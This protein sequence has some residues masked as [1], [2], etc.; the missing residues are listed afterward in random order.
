MCATLDMRSRACNCTSKTQQEDR[1][2]FPKGYGYSPMKQ[3]MKSGFQS[4]RRRVRSAGVRAGREEGGALYELAMV[5]PVLSMLLVGIIYG[6]ITFY[7]YV[8]LANAVA[9]GAR[10]LALN[11]SAFAGPP[12]ACQLEEAALKNAAGNLNPLQITIAPESFVGASKCSDLLQDDTATVSATYPCNL[13]IPFAGINL[14]P[15]QGTTSKTSNA[16]CPNSAYCLSATMTV[17]IQ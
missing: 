3:S 5:A 15:V 16:N 7:D 11:R 10:T 9:V 6:G 8:E 4:L 14:C 17:L 2:E 13:P 1:S 12:T